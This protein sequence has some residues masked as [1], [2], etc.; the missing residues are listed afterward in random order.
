MI[1]LNDTNHNG[2]ATSPAKKD[3]KGIYLFNAA[4]DFHDAIVKY[5]DLGVVVENATVSELSPMIQ[6]STFTLNAYGI[7]LNIK[8]S[9]DIASWIGN[10]IFD[11]NDFGVVTDAD[12]GTIGKSIPTL[13]ENQFIN[14]TDAKS[15]RQH[16]NGFPNLSRR[17]SRTGLRQQQFCE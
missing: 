17:N 14:Q 15:G 11:G 4:T 9:G 13:S 1:V 7:Y 16:T 2:S 3:W 10:N 8:S 12:T 6:D 5:G